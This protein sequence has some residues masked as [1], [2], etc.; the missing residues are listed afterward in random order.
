[1]SA[2]QTNTRGGGQNRGRG[3]PRPNRGRGGGRPAQHSA[4]ARTMATA[5][6]SGAGNEVKPELLNSGR[7]SPSGGASQTRFADLPGLDAKLLA[8]LP[9]EF[10]TEVSHVFFSSLLFSG[11]S[12]RN[13]ALLVLDFDP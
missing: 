9:F 12:P 13:A 8:S 7:T 4:V 6:S 11:T 3:G 2:P 5:S 10:A 1:M